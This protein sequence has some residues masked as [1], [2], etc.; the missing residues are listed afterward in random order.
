MRTYSVV[1]IRSELP[2]GYDGVLGWNF[3]DTRIIEVGHPTYAIFEVFIRGSGCFRN[4][5]KKN[6]VRRW[7]TNV[8]YNGLFCRAISGK[9]IVRLRY[10][11]YISASDAT[12]AGGK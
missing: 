7:C 1:V 4:G 11:M 8:S 5:T 12:T 2:T 6:L 9:S 10:G 3:G